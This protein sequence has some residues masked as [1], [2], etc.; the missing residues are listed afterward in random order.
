MDCRRAPTRNP[1]EWLDT[2]PEFSRPMAEQYR[3]WFGQWQPDLRESI[4]WNCLCYSGC[5]L[6][7]GLSPCQRHLGIVFF[8]GSELDDP[9]G[10][11]DPG[12]AHN[13]SIKTIRLTD[14]H[15]LPRDPV[16]VLL[17]AAVALDED[18]LI[19]GPLPKK[20][21]PLPLPPL[22]KEALQQDRQAH[23]GFTQLAPTYQREYIVW[24]TSAKRPET[25]QK[26]LAQTLAALRQGRRWLDRPRE[27]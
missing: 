9:A 27:V 18:P 17:R 6:V 2:T 4:K 16:K 10:L 15:H 7:V 8:R 24:L 3:E 26:R 23:T 13:L 14:P 11:F 1:D 21:P 22:L 19:C 25:Q 20:R 5:K 12:S